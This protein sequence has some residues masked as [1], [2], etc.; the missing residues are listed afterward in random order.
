MKNINKQ[1]SKSASSTTVINLEVCKIN[2]L[3]LSLV[4]RSIK[5]SLSLKL[6]TTETRPGTLAAMLTSMSY[7]CVQ[8]SNTFSQ[9]ILNANV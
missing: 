4:M 5:Q 6:P 1:P 9:A 8:L 3:N 2:L 7:I